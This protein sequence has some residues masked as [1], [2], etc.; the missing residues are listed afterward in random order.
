ML[1]FNSLRDLQ[2][3]KNMYALTKALH[4]IIIWPV[5]ILTLKKSWK[6]DV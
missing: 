2:E 4:V 5:L 1:W 6:V 3:V